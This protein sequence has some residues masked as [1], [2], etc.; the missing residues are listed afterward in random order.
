MPKII[1]LSDGQTWDSIDGCMEITLCEEE[2]EKL[3]MA[4]RFSSDVKINE[5]RTLS[6]LDT[7]WEEVAHMFYKAC[8]GKDNNP[9][10]D[11]DWLEELLQYWSGHFHVEEYDDEG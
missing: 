11:A 6:E 4:D 1:V 7:D 10:A 9:P 3:C 5:Q 8:G 2:L